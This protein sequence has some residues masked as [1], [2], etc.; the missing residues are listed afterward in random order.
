MRGVPY[1]YIYFTYVFGVYHHFPDGIVID[2]ERDLGTEEFVLD[3]LDEFLFL[4]FP[5]VSDALS[6]EQGE[7][8]GGLR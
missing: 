4:G 1:I 5:V 6:R 7:F 2:R 8:V 3:T